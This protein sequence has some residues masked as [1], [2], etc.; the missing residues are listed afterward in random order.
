MCRV[1]FFFLAL[2]ADVF[3]AGARFGIG[4][5]ARDTYCRS[6]FIFFR[7]VGRSL[8]VFIYCPMVCTR[9]WHPCAFRNMAIYGAVNVFFY[10]LGAVISC[11]G[12][13]GNIDCRER[14]SR[15]SASGAWSV[16]SSKYVWWLFGRGHAYD[17]GTFVFGRAG[18]AI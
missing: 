1:V 12:P 7:V 17:S 16:F 14:V 13:G 11:P 6:V 2:C 18:S 9:Q 8:F 4:V 10:A 5:S 3:I 15:T